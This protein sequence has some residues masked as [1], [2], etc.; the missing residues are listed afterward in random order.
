MIVVADAS[1]LIA[2]ARIGRLE[3]LPSLF[4]SLML[5]DAVWCE[6]VETNLP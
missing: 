1:S 4:G 2:L 3:L 6:L 5:P